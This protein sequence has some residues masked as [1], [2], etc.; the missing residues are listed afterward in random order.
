MTKNFVAK[1]RKNI[2]RT[3][4]AEEKIHIVVE[5]FCGEILISELDRRKGISV[6]NFNSQLRRQ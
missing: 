2:R 1:I 5:T 4:L 3:F 6:A